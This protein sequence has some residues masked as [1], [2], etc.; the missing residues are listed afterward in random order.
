M[1]AS[2]G[3]GFAPGRCTKKFSRLAAKLIEVRLD[4][5][6]GH[7]VSIAARGPRPGAK[8]DSRA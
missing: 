8:E 3:I 4:G 6:L 5:K 2:Q 7:D 1:N